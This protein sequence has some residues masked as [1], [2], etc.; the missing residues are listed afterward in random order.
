MVQSLSGTFDN[1]VWVDW[2]S[3]DG[4]SGYER[5]GDGCPSWTAP[6]DYCYGPAVATKPTVDDTSIA[7][8]FTTD[9]YDVPPLSTAVDAIARVGDTITY[10]LSLDLRGGLTSDVRVQDVL[11]TG[12][13]FVDV[14]SINGDT[15]ADYTAPA[16]GPGSNFAY[17]PITAANVP[18]ADQ[19]GTLTWTI[20]DV[21]NDPFGDPTTDSLEIIYRARILPDAGIAHVDSTTL[22]NTASLG[23][24]GAP[25]LNSTAVVT[26]HQPVIAQV[27]KIDRGGRTSP[28]PVNVTSDNMQ[29]R[30]EI[31]GEQADWSPDS[32]KIVYRSGILNDKLF[33]FHISSLNN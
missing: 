18:A 33:R 14:V 7:K 12:M 8:A 29:F 3:L 4:D 9:T 22:N 19:T 23:Y 30:F 20:G 25:L 5:T 6:N 28:T 24:D 10:R 1:N 32:E 13:A 17:V 11:P 31:L 2:T 26:L 27:T 16:G 21:V 15:T